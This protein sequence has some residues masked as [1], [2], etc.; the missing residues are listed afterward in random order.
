MDGCD[1]PILSPKLPLKCS[2][3]Q[4]AEG[5]QYLH[6]R[7]DRVGPKRVAPKCWLQVVAQI[8]KN[9]SWEPEASKEEL[10]AL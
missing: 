6:M 8:Y 5:R 1:M 9:W 10:I 2:S 7:R 3:G 4:K